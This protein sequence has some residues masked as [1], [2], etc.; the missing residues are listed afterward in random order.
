MTSKTYSHKCR[1]CK[2]HWNTKAM[3][4]VSP[5]SWGCRD[6]KACQQRIDAAH[7][8]RPDVPTT[9][10][11]LMV[12]LSRVLNTALTL[13]FHERFDL[14]KYIGLEMMGFEETSKRIQPI[15][16]SPLP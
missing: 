5:G 15:P 1:Y 3:V 2:Q 11:A 8:Q 16:L 13:P 7:V 14:V 12:K 6:A 10:D 9:N 4:K